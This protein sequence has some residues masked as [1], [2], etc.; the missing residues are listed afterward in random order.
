MTVV[1][2]AALSPLFSRTRRGA[3]S[4]AYLESLGITDVV[5]C[6]LLTSV[7]VLFTMQSAFARGF[8]VR[9][10]AEGCADRT[11]ARHNAAIAMYDNYCFER[12]DDLATVFE[13]HTETDS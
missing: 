4:Q 2:V 1:V 8:R 3:N 6:G 5:F 7:C 10:Y 13:E 11:R 12:C 9:L